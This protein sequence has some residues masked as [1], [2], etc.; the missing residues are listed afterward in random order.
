MSS[1]V[2]CSSAA[3][4]VSV[5]SRIPAQI[6]ATPTGWMMKSSPELPALV[7]VVHA[8]VDERLLDPVAVDRRRPTRGRAPRRSRT[9]RRAAAARPRSARSARRRRGRRDARRGRPA[10]ARRRTRAD[11]LPSS[12]GGSSPPRPSGGSGSASWEL[13]CAAQKSSS[14]LVSLCV[15]PVRR[16]ALERCRRGARDRQGR[17]IPVEA[18][19][20][21]LREDPDQPARQTCRAAVRTVAAKQ[22]LELLAGHPPPQPEA[23][24]ESHE[25]STETVLQ[26]VHLLSKA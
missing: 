11:P 2:S 25:R 9:G 6:L 17:Q 20:L 15:D 1:T 18:D 8:R 21:Q 19:E 4:S 7:G 13:V 26:L 12:A 24:V 14:V 10:G 22:V 3:H 23:P 16:R 5:S